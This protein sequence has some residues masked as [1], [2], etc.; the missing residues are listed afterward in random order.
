MLTEVLFTCEL[1]QSGR[2]YSEKENNEIYIS[3]LVSTEFSYYFC[4]TDK[5]LVMLTKYGREWRRG[6]LS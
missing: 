5:T 2:P 4:N 3:T 1:R 6:G